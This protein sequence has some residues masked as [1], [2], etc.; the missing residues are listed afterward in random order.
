VE[1][2][3][4]APMLKADG[5]LVRRTKGTPQGGPVSP[6]IANVFLHYGFDLWMTREFP[7]VL[8]E[9]FAD[10]VVVHCVTERQA[11]Q[12]REAIGHRLAEVG[13]ELHPGKTRIVYCKDTDLRPAID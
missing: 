8:F 2:W 7:G 13:L 11:R 1:R 5:V 9:R 10:D 6:L 12:V 4:K 3:L